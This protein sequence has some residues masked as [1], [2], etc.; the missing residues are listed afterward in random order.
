[1]CHIAQITMSELQLHVKRDRNF[2]Q[3]SCEIYKALRNINNAQAKC[4]TYKSLETKKYTKRK[5][6]KKMKKISEF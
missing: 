1:M 4:T 5:M 3:F 2:F 6:K